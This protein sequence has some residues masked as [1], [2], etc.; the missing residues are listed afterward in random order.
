MDIENTY[1]QS[2]QKHDEV[3][4]LS[5]FD[6]L[7]RSETSIT[8]SGWYMYIEKTLSYLLFD[9]SKVFLSFGGNM[10]EI[11]ESSVAK[12]SETE[13]GNIFELYQESNLLL[14]FAYPKPSE[15][16]EDDI[17]GFTED[18]DFNWGLFLRN[19]INSV[20][21]REIIFEEINKKKVNAL[22]P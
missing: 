3:L 2:F 15:N 21:R 14:R 9:E 18:E 12:L 20:S 17:F 7:K 6:T 5:N 4:K 22:K 8:T 10:F 19:I 1:L 16:L 13:S 11:D